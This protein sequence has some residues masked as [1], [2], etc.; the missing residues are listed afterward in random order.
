MV[1]FS[2]SFLLKTSETLLLYH[3][4]NIKAKNIINVNIIKTD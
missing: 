4:I 1:Y 2:Y 3:L